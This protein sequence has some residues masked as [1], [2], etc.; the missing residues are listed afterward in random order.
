NELLYVGFNQDN[1][2]F[3]CGTESGF[4]AY[5]VDPFREFFRNVFKEGGI[6]IVEMLYRCNIMALVGGGR[7]PL[8]PVNKVM[9]WDNEIHRCIGELMFKNE[10]KA[11]KLRRD[12]VVVVLLQ[13]V[14]V[15]RFSDLK[16]LD[17]I[18]TLPNVRG[19]VSLCPDSSHTVL[20]CPGIQKG[21]IR[22]ELY[23][24][25]KAMLIKAHDSDLAQIALNID[26]R[27]IRIASASDKG[28]LIRV[29]DCASGELLRELRR[30]VDR[31]EIYCLCFNPLS[32]FLACSSDKG[33]VHIFSLTDAVSN[34][35]GMVPNESG[36]ASARSGAPVGGGAAAAS[37]VSGV[38]GAEGSEQDPSNA[39][40]GLAF[41]KD[42]L[43]ASIVPKYL[44]SEWSYAQVRGLEGKCICAFDRDS[45]KI[46]VI[47]ANGTFLTSS[48]E[49]GGE[50]ER[51]TFAKF[52]KSDSE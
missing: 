48:Y 35:V 33:T 18:T 23:D 1:G 11:V 7:N 20:A 47:C 10:V 36:G 41:I 39:R 24:I 13:K 17:Q 43:P 21:T 45:S 29:W 30:G 19:L 38:R 8:Y 26:G 46:I 37:N 14:Y 9:I 27:Y 34:N 49:E 22:V 42:L 2:C 6:G 3:A 51:L 15:Y 16:L 52:V 32:T 25:S 4:R 31:A 40:S 5:N 12:H 28:T 50:C 44:V